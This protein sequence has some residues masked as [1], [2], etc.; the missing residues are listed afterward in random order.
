MRN[1]TEHPASPSPPETVARQME[2][3][4]PIKNGNLHSSFPLVSRVVRKRR[5]ISQP[6]FVTVC[7]LVAAS[8]EPENC[9]WLNMEWVFE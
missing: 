8:F 6:L 1:W 4:L 2:M 7:H 9:L 5:G 3:H